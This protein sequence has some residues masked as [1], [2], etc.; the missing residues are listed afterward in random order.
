MELFFVATHKKTAREPFSRSLF[1]A[2][3]LIELLVV[4]AIIAILA[5][6]L[7]PAL[8]AAKEK[9]RSIK[10]ISNHKQI[11][12]AWNLYKD[13]N[14]G[15]F[16]EDNAG[17]Q[18]YPCWAKGDMSNPVEAT[19]LTIFK[20][21]LLVAYAP[22]AGVYKCPDDQTPH[23]RSYSMQPQMA[24]YF[25][26][27]KG[28]SQKDNGMPGY[29]PMFK[30]GDV[31]HTAPSFTFVFIDEASAEINDAMIGLFIAKPQWWDYPASWHSKGCNL[32]FVDGHAEHWKWK[33]PGT[34][35]ATSG[36]AAGIDL[37]NLQQDLGYGP[38]F[39]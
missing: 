13:D 26:G 28:D 15:Y 24:Y 32:S 9:A 17:N 11:I 19:N 39:Q 23:I 35:A 21:G 29:P 22:N 4:I 2:F 30:E 7:L 1:R 34:P 25:Y 18:P 38:P 8:S 31:I 6:M 33:D 37:T 36:S 5:A 20:T 10:C 14:N 27:V 16:V 3:T 12:L